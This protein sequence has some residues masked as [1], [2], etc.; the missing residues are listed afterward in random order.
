MANEARRT[1]GDTRGGGGADRKRLTASRLT[2]RA[3]SW[4]VGNR[5]NMKQLFRLMVWLVAAL[6]LRVAAADTNSLV[7]YATGFEKTEGFDPRLELLGQRGWVGVGTGGNGLVDGFFAGLGQQ[8]F[9][10]YAPPTD[11]NLSLSVWYPDANIKTQ[12]N[13]IRFSVDMSIEDST[14]TNYDDFRWSV[15]NTNGQ[16]HFSLDF[17]NDARLITFAL[18]DPAGFISTGR[19]FTNGAMYR[20]VIDMD[21][22][23][24]RWNAT[25]DGDLLVEYQP[26]TT[27]GNALNFG[28]AD[29]VWF[30]RK[31]GAPGDNFMLFDNYQIMA[32]PTPLPAPAPPRFAAIQR[33]NPNQVLL[34][35]RGSLNQFCQVEFSDDLAQWKPLKTAA[36]T[37]TGSLDLV[38]DA[39]ASRATRFYRASYAP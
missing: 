28:D 34:R 10:G 25:I 26:I 6:S 36:F 13:R 31:P 21:F 35:L 16:R 24:N 32:V 14:G 5:N 11:T 39:A 2:E 9:V 15:Y 8:A 22:Q 18:D 1:G 37:N 19:A 7:L 30:I 20:V 4:F 3:V 29:A 12:Y 27:A 38:D 33:L 17:D 23:S